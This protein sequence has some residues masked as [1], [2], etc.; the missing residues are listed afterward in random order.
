MKNHVWMILRRANFTQYKFRVRKYE[1][2]G[3]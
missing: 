2:V 1:G 3:E